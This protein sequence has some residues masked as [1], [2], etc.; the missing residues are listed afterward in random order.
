[1]GFFK[2]LAEAQKNYNQRQ[3]EQQQKREEK[4]K[5][6]N[7]Q[8]IIYCP[9]CLSTQVTANKRGFS[10]GKAIA[11]NIVAGPVGLV[12]GAFGSRTV[13]ITCLKCGYRWKAGGR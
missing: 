1:M 2:Q 10:A 6:L 12:A 11:G 5:E 4:I 9:K 13:E 7:S 8:G 3:W